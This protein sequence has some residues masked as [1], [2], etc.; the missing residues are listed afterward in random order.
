M[1]LRNVVAVRAAHLALGLSG[2]QRAC[3]SAVLSSIPDVV[4]TR[5]SRATLLAAHEA[6]WR[7][8]SMDDDDPRRTLLSV[9]D[10]LRRALLALS[11]PRVPAVIRGEALCTAL[12]DLPKEEATTV[13][14]TVL[15]A[16]LDTNLVPA[17]TAETVAALVSGIA[18]GGATVSGFGPH[19]E[20][21]IDVRR[22]LSL[23]AVPR[24]D[25][26]FLHGVIAKFCTPAQQLTGTELPNADAIIARLLQVREDCHAALATR[27]RAA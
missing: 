23:T 3:R 18:F 6:A 25:V 24:N 4:R 13:A 5:V 8:T 10:P 27:V 1:L 14:W 7:E 20:W 22:R 11:L 15:P 2:D 17:T 16:V 12:A 21:A 9:H 19:R 26:E